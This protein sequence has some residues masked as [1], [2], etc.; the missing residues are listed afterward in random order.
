MNR[1]IAIDTR[2]A[3]DATCIQPSARSAADS[4]VSPFATVAL[5]PPIRAVGVD[6]GNG[7]MR[8]GFGPVCSTDHAPAPAASSR[9][10]LGPRSHQCPAPTE[11]WPVGRGIFS[12]TATPAADIRSRGCV[13]PASPGSSVMIA[14]ASVATW[15]CWPACFLCLSGSPV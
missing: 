6:S 1:G 12:V 14:P 10:R 2:E 15:A 13:Q 11:V 9:V 4:C 5:K 3:P 7:G 8:F